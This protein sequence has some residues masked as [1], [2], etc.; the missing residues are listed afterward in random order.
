MTP[1]F[2]F[3]KKGHWLL[4]PFLFL[5]LSCVNRTV[6]TE[7]YNL[8]RIALTAAKD[9]EAKRYAPKVYSKAIQYMRKAERAYNE[10]Y[11]E[12]STGYFRKSRYYS[13]RAENISRVKM[14]SQ[15]EMT[16]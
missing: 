1:I 10:R 12:K 2:I 15:G 11:F 4:C 5:T 9:S 14:F 3:F 7:E 8:A 6:P 16:P 13:E